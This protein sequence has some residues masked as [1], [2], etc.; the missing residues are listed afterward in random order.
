[1]IL[2]G[3]VRHDEEST[4]RITTFRAWVSNAMTNGAGAAKRAGHAI[5]RRMRP[6]GDAID[7][8]VGVGDDESGFGGSRGSRAWIEIIEEY[9]KKLRELF[10]KSTYERFSR[11]ESF[12]RKFLGLPP[13]KAPPLAAP[14]PRQRMAAPPPVSPEM[15]ARM[16]AQIRAGRQQATTQDRVSLRQLAENEESDDDDLAG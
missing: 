3:A 12:I 16:R 9:V 6:G 4:V 7:A 8:G 1:L 15:A 11:L 2:R 10:H 13:R 14:K 5:S